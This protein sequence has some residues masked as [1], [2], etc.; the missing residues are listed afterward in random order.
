M[1]KK[2]LVGL[3]SLFGAATFA[4]SGCGGSCDDNAQVQCNTSHNTCVTTC[5]SPITNTNYQGC[6]DGCNT[7]L[8]KC[9]EDAGCA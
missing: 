5:G 3:V 2:L 8:N 4:L 9:L 1:K 7:T 6:V